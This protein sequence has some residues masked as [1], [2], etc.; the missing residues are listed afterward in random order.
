MKR[1]KAKDQKQL[2]KAAKEFQKQQS[3]N[4][5][6]YSYDTILEVLRCREVMPNHLIAK[7]LNKSIG[8]VNKITSS[9]DMVQLQSP[10]MKEKAIAAAADIL[11]G[12]DNTN[13]VKVIGMIFENEKK[14][15][16]SHAVNINI[17]PYEKDFTNDD[18]KHE[19]VV[20]Y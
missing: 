6:S 2:A 18:F 15:T 9:L 3:P 20:V 17:K 19:D 11:D 10:V 14:S 4:S 5:S 12:E 1:D 7:V 8:T 13:R 16:P